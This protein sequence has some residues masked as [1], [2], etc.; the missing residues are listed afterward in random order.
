[1]IDEFVAGRRHWLAV[2]REEAAELRRVPHL[3]AL[4]RRIDTLEL[5]RIR[6]TVDRIGRG[7]E[8]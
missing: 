1:V 5:T 6:K 2:E 3:D 8:Q 4:V 7:F